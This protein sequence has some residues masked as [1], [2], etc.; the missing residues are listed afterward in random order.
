MPRTAVAIAVTLALVTAVLAALLT[1]PLGRLPV[2][3]KSTA[4]PT[5]TRIGTGQSRRR[6]AQPR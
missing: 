6:H 4:A 3:M 5:A 1:W 2:A